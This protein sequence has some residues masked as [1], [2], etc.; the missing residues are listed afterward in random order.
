[1][2]SY[3]SEK[4]LIRLTAHVQLCSH[5]YGGPNVLSDRTGKFNSVSELMDTMNA[6]E[7]VFPLDNLVRIVEGNNQVFGKVMN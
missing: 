7:T 3:V 4:F 6:L 2:K 5:H 1:M